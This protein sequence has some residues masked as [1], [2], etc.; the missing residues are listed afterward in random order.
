MEPAAS[1]K[2]ARAAAQRA[3]HSDP[4]TQARREALLAAA[5]AEADALQRRRC[6]RGGRCAKWRRAARWAAR[7]ARPEVVFLVHGRRG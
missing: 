5:R 1:D 7:V 4:D 2:N 3:P 6:P